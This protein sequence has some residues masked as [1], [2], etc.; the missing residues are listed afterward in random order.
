MMHIVTRAIEL[1][2][3]LLNSPVHTASNLHI[4]S[5]QCQSASHVDQ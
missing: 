2:N 4:V 3:L 5:H 1:H